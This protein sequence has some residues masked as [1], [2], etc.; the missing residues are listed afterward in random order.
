MEGERVFANGLGFFCSGTGEG[1]VELDNVGS[2][3]LE[4]PFWRKSR[5]GWESDFWEDW[6]GVS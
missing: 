3:V 4:V 2:V 5:V 6:S 1:D